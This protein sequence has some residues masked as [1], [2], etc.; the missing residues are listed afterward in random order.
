[1]RLITEDTLFHCYQSES[2]SKHVF[3]IGLA[4]PALNDLKNI[5][6]TSKSVV[7]GAWVFLENSVL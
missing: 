3:V 1:M 2:D 4:I 5:V 7:G 6:E